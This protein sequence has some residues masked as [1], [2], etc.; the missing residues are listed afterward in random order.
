[1]L[2]FIPAGVK[3]FLFFIFGRGSLVKRKYK[4]MSPKG[5]QK[6]LNSKKVGF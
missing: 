2:F 4:P 3:D 1:M 5:R 6:R